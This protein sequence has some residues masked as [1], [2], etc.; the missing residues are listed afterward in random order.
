M[1]KDVTQV[2]HVFYRGHL[3]GLQ[4][5]PISDPFPVS[6]DNTVTVIGEFPEEPYEVTTPILVVLTSVGNEFLAS[7]AEANMAMTG[8]TPSE[9]IGNLAADILDT[10]ELYSAEEGN[11]GPEPKRQLAILRRYIAKR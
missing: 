2:A 7:F 8:S 9:A 3:P 10:Y 4:V 11:L 1:R 6:A 5:F